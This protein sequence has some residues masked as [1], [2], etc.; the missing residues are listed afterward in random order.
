[1]HVNIPV[2]SDNQRHESTTI[3]GQLPL[4][5]LHYGA[6]HL[7]RLQPPCAHYS[8]LIYSEPGVGADLRIQ[9][10]KTSFR[11]VITNLLSKNVAK[12]IR[13]TYFG[14][15]LGSIGMP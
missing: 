1:M 15:L 10:N 14:R 7:W 2:N 13:L 11:G 4:T 12:V 3:F 6:S 5:G 8:A 9:Q